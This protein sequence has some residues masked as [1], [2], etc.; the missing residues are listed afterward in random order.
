MSNVWHWPR[1]TCICIG[2]FSWYFA[3]PGR[4]DKYIRTCMDMWLSCQV[5][6][7]PGLSTFVY[8]QTFQPHVFALNPA[9][10]CKSWILA[11]RRVQRVD[12]WCKYFVCVS[13]GFRDPWLKYWI[14]LHYT[15]IIHCVFLVQCL[16]KSLCP[17][18]CSTNPRCNQQS[19]FLR[20]V[21]LGTWNHW[22]ATL[23]GIGRMFPSMSLVLKVIGAW[24]PVGQ[25]SIC[26]DVFWV[27][28]SISTRSIECLQLQVP[29]YPGNSP[30]SLTQ[31]Q[32][33]MLNSS[34][35]S[36]VAVTGIWLLAPWT[37]LNWN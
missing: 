16:S 4:L 26:V 20:H 24:K 17:L 22:G 14:V 15:V 21:L 2:V 25:G 12:F 11:L 23:W 9:W 30:Q 3:F 18:F 28:P 29:R 1:I 7:C 5:C 33:K 35:S 34:S 27:G 13:R 19:S 8:L 32:P 31:Q 36:S 10:A 37:L 6:W